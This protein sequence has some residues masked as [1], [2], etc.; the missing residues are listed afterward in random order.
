MVDPKP[1]K[2]GNEKPAHHQICSGI[3]KIEEKQPNQAI[4]EVPVVH[5]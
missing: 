2:F 4:E 3:P 1:Q 5:L